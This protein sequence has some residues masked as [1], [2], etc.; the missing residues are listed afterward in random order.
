MTLF[1]TIHHQ[2]QHHHHQVEIWVLLG[3]SP[4][5]NA[6]GIQ[7]KACRAI[8]SVPSFGGKDDDDDDGNQNG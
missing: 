8:I 2:Q 3:R 4:P 6:V 1:A 5:S 7:S